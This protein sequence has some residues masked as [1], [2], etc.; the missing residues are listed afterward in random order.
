MNESKGLSAGQRWWQFGAQLRDHYDVPRVQIAQLAAQMIAAA[1]QLREVAKPFYLKRDE[2]LTSQ[3]WNVLRSEADRLWKS[4]TFVV[5]KSLRGDEWESRGISPFSG[6]TP[7]ES[8]PGLYER[9]RQWV[10]GLV[11]GRI[12]ERPDELFDLLLL[13][14]NEAL[15]SAPELSASSEVSELMEKLADVQP[16]ERV[17]CVFAGAA[18][19][20]LRIARHGHRVVIEIPSQEGAVFWSSLATAADLPVSV[21][22]VDPFQTLRAKWQSAERDFDAVI[23]VPPFGMKVPLQAPPGSGLGLPP[24]TSEA[25]AV[26][27]AARRG[28]RRS[29]CLLPNGFLFRASALDQQ[30][31]DR[32]LHQFGLDAVVGL[33]PG[34]AVRG[35]GVA[36]SLL[37]L[38]PGKAADAVLM[39]EGRG[40]HGR[41]NINRDDVAQIVELVRRRENRGSTR[42]VAFDEIAA[43]QFNLLPERYILSEDDERLQ[44]LL[45]RAEAVP[46]GD[47]VE[48]YRAQATPAVAEGHQSVDGSTTLELS[49]S[50][51]D[52]VGLARTPTKRLLVSEEDYFKLRKAELR[53]GDVLLVTKGSVG[54]VGYVG[55][56][57]E[58]EYWVANQ[59]FAILRLRRNSPLRDSRVLFRYL[60]SRTGQTLLS[61]L[62]VGATISTLQ[63][64]D[65]KQVPILIPPPADQHRVASEVEGLFTMQTHINDLRSQ[66][67]ARQ[68]SI[69]PEA[70][71]GIASDAD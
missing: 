20:A 16:G 68:L 44:D 36:S 26:A 51:L 28:R 41:K 4:E 70:E 42:V 9:V 27:V 62:R 29:L 8:S 53:P 30:F 40:K 17:L 5:G 69:W 33:P 58:D 60:G 66:L 7:I 1:R 22:A 11:E 56:I 6:S 18:D 71:L 46:L 21:L 19:T 49:V 38:E 64:A 57:P 12:F 14:A 32:T 24:P 34:A 61:R 45:G 23:V 54:K 10:D 39:V 55:D 48:I 67:A 50:D 13:I 3:G 31:K 52:D 47:L 63:M 2:E 59:S 35:S 65:I 15:A 25:W 43:N 37:L